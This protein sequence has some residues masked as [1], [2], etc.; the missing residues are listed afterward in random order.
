MV[1]FRYAGMI[2]GEPN[3]YPSLDPEACARLND[4]LNADIPEF[5]PGSSLPSCT[6]EPSASWLQPPAAT[7]PGPFSSTAET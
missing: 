1:G 5:D 7:T 2:R 4:Q 3:Q 6:R